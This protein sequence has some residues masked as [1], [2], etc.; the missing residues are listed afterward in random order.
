MATGIGVLRGL[1]ASPLKVERGYEHGRA[2]LTVLIKQNK[3]RLQL[4]SSFQ[5]AVHFLDFFPWRV[6]SVQKPTGASFRHNLNM[7]RSEKQNSYTDYYLRQW[8][9]YSKRTLTTRTSDN[10]TQIQYILFITTRNSG[11]TYKKNRHM[12]MNSIIVS[13]SVIFLYVH[14]LYNN[15][16]HLV[17][18]RTVLL[19][20][21]KK[22]YYFF[23]K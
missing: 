17:T 1:S 12:W 16:Y 18:L 11:L 3:L 7:N 14:M 9:W 4:G 5:C 2:W 15:L 21:K 19:L 20:M 13:N 8:E 10:I 23:K 22:D 6:W